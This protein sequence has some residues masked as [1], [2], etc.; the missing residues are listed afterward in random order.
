MGPSRHVP[1]ADM[2]QAEKTNQEH[3]SNPANFLPVGRLPVCQEHHWEK[4]EKVGDKGSMVLLQLPN[5]VSEHGEVLRAR[6]GGV[7]HFH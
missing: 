5:F 3:T 1:F 2:S 7:S 4:D 6:C